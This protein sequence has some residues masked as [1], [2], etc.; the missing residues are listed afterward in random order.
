MKTKKFQQGFSLLEILVAFSILAFSL[1]IVLKIFSSSL[2]TATV[3]EDYTLAIEIAESL[4]AKTGTE[5][6]LALGEQA[7]ETDP[8]FT[9][10]INVIPIALD[11]SPQLPEGLAKRVV[12]VTVHVQWGDEKQPRS[13][14]L[15]TL[16]VL[17]F[18]DESTS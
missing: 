14:D 4:L 9:W 12:Q 10:Q 18:T 13:L 2:R 17:A 7:G 3:A 15:S 8:H 1:G 16:K 5:K 11:I 6:K